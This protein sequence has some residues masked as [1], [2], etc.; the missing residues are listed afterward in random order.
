MKLTDRTVADLLAAFRSSTPTPGG[1]SASALAGAIGASLLAMVAGLPRSRAATE[2]DVERLGAA[3]VRC[4]GLSNRL[5]ALVD[6]D[7][8]AYE[9]VV[10][11]YALPKETDEQK[12]AR[13]GHIQ[14]ALR[15]ATDAPLAVMRACRDAIEQGQVVAQL[16]S[17]NASSDVQVAMELL[18]AG[19]RG[20]GVN[21]E[22]N[23]GSVKNDAYVEAV[24]EE[25]ARLSLEADKG[26]TSA[27]ARLGAAS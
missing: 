9:R 13:S 22:I 23:L 3:G 24:R 20:A 8:E 18:G 4:A 25:I 7:S 27:R 5:A 6:L 21:V 17:R 15:A 19:F 26:V 10:S 14:E 16:G 11:A 12:T 2:E 1:G